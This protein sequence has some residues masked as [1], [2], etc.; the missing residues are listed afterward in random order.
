M[1]RLSFG[2]KTAP[3]EFNR[4]LDQILQGLEGTISYF[5]DIII[6]SETNALSNVLKNYKKSI[7][8]Q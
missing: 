6:H 3:S 7:T 8:R 5:D 1:N 4:I 2:I